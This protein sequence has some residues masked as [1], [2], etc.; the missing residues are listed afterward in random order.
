M[1]YENLMEGSK[2]MTQNAR[3]TAKKSVLS[4]CNPQNKTY[5][6]N[7]FFVNVLSHYKT[8]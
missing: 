3:I 6:S 7:K 8:K 2:P 1:L 4:F 5:Q